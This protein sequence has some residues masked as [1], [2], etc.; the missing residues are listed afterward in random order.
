[1]V[2]WC[3]TGVASPV[4]HV[5]LHGAMVQ[6]R[7][8]KPCVTCCSPWCYGA[9]QESQ[10][11]CYMLLSMVLWC[12][13]GVAS[14]VLHV[15]LHGAMVQHMLHV[16]LS[17]MCA[18]R[19]SHN[20]VGHVLLSRVLETERCLCRAR[21]WLWTDARHLALQ[22]DTDTSSLV[23]SLVFQ[24]SYITVQYPKNFTCPGPSIFA[25]CKAGHWN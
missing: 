19:R 22:V 3:N 10:A 14:P 12:N 13:T 17:C 18:E 16:A 8:R 24:P 2:L 20:G 23:Y 6:H 7:S 25:H 15:A 11:L 1:M 21:Q 9:T 4:L 5:A